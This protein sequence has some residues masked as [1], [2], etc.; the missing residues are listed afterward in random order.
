MKKQDLTQNKLKN[1]KSKV[2]GWFDKP[3]QFNSWI[4]FNYIKLSK[5][6][7]RS[8]SKNALKK[9]CNK[10]FDGNFDSMKSDGGH[11]NGKIFVGKNNKIKLNEYIAEFVIAEYKKR[12][13]KW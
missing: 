4:L 8:I 10:K 5:G 3:Y 7:S 9:E 13:F 1:L 11:N 2:K 6:N 12:G